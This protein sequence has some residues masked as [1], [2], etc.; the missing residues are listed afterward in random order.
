M[1][2]TYI[3]LY[4]VISG[5]GSERVNNKLIYGPLKTSAALHVPKNGALPLQFKEQQHQNHLKFRSE[6]RRHFV[7]FIEAVCVG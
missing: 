3:L 2:F 5:I 1:H 7:V 6:T 4:P